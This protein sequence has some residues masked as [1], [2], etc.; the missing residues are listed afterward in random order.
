[1]LIQYLIYT[2]VCIALNLSTTGN[3]ILDSLK[4]G[5]P[6][7]RRAGSTQYAH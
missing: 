1:M 4:L 3:E 6:M 2:I 7:P 5:R